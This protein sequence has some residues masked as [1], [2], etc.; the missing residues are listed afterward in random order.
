ME[1]LVM[2]SSQASASRLRLRSVC[3]RAAAVNRVSKTRSKRVNGGSVAGSLVESG[4][5]WQPH[6]SVTRRTAKIAR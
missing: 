2:T 1:S 3:T 4:V 5:L 6:R